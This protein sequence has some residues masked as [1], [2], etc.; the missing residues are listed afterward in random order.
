MFSGKLQLLLVGAVVLALANALACTREVVKEVPV[1]VQ[2]VKEVEVEVMVDR[3]V[4]KTVPVEVEKVVEVIRE[5]PVEV[6]KQVIVE[7][8]VVV[9]KEVIK[10]V[11]VEVVKVVESEVRVMVDQEPKTL[12]FAIGQTYPNIV[13]HLAKSSGMSLLFDLVYSRIA[14]PNPNGFFTADLAERWEVAPDAT[15]YTFFLRKDARWHDG[16]PV[17]ANDIKFMWTVL[18]EPEFPSWKASSF[19]IV[20][21]GQDYLDGNA[22][23][24]EGLVVIDDYT[25]R[26]DM[27][28][29]SSIFFQTCCS[30]RNPIYPEH[31]YGNVAPADMQTHP[32]FTNAEIPVGSGPFKFVEHVSDQFALLDAN[33][34]Y[35]FGRP[36]LDHIL[37]SMI[38]QRDA[39]QI[40]MTRGELDILYH[41]LSPEGNAALVADPRFTVKGVQGSVIGSYAWNHDVE[42]LRDSRIRHAFLHALDR[43]KIINVFSTG[44]GTIF[45]NP[46]THSWYQDPAWKDRFPFDP[47][48]SRSLLA[49]AG[50]D[51]NRVVKVLTGTPRDEKAS[52]QLAAV[53][54]MLADVGMTIEYDTVDGAARTEKTENGDFDIFT[55]GF[56]VHSDPD[57]FLKNRLHTN[58]ENLMRY[59]SPEFDVLIEAGGNAIDPKERAKIYREIAEI[60]MQDM[61]LSTTYMTNSWY[62]MRKEV[63]IPHFDSVG[64]PTSLYDVQVAPSFTH[65]LDVW[66]YHVEEWDLDN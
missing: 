66:N 32:S 20:K 23:S 44:N 9:E 16:E 35:H 25:I 14:M 37:I 62:A 6:E 59:A 39:R 49:D 4:I 34:D 26:F 29:P 52:A 5:V 17:T 55:G 56:S 63:R 61:P 15:S 48:K 27:E 45:N 31:I 58:S 2:V 1:E 18:L 43:Q 33:S 46:L 38:T 21:G 47:D 41:G 8:E 7:R 65:R 3:E 64:D 19:T 50:W 42:D 22:D 54:Q 51:S 36:N 24:V 30:L 40:A 10:E 12:R 53:Q 57:G 13:T 28:N 60:L 11:P